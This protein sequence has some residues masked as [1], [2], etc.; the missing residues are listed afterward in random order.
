MKHRNILLPLLGSLI[1]C[2]CSITTGT[3][4]AKAD[5]YTRL[6]KLETNAN[7]DE[8]KSV[9]DLIMNQTIEGYDKA[10][11]LNQTVHEEDAR[12]D[13]GTLDK[14]IRTQQTV[15]MQWLNEDKELFQVMRN[16]SV[17]GLPPYVGLVRIDKPATTSVSLN[18][19]E[20]EDV[21]GNPLDLSVQYV[22]TS[23]NKA[24]K[25]LSDEQ[26]G[27]RLISEELQILTPYFG[28]D[29]AVP[30]YS[31]PRL[32]Q[33]AAEQ[34]G[35]DIVFTVTLQNPE[36]Y[37]SRAKEQDGA[38]TDILRSSKIDSYE[39]S[40][41]SM[42]WT[43]Q[44]DSQ[45]VLNHVQ[46][47]VQETIQSNGQSVTLNSTRTADLEGCSSNQSVGYLKDLFEDVDNGSL[48]QGSTLTLDLPIKAAPQTN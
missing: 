16:G 30:P 29:A 34:S 22:S 28:S 10:F 23:E 43:L 12:L 17:D 21:F 42:V 35:E 6:K 20:G 37:N 9:F 7:T 31:N 24:L 32:F 44:M 5:V 19:K 8:V 46:L 27:Y 18:L 15:V 25:D 47:D 2:S 39:A 11:E 13:N 26:I 48:R 36:A 3:S 45:G 4:D 14:D 40:T 1:L 38:R 33:F 41:D